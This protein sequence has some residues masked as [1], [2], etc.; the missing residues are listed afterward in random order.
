MRPQDQGVIQRKGTLIVASCRRKKIGH[1][2]FVFEPPVLEDSEWAPEE[3]DDDVW[4][5]W[6]LIMSVSLYNYSSASSAMDCVFNQDTRLGVFTKTIKNLNREKIDRLR[7]FPCPRCEKCG[8]QEMTLKKVF[9]SAIPKCV[10][11]HFWPP[12]L[13]H[14]SKS[15]RN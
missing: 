5:I 7:L 3:M 6:I 12:H 13:C 2:P 11:G 4:R 14:P 9:V 10:S 1:P 8:H 15:T